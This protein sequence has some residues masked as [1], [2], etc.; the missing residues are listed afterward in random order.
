MSKRKMSEHFDLI[1][2]GGGSGGV[3]ASKRAAS[4]GA[5]V[6]IIEK[7]RFGGTCVNRGCIPKKLLAY[8]SQFRTACHLAGAFAG[9]SE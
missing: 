4:Y 3:A 8:A 6:A 2:I 7:S 1:T 5:R 9:Q